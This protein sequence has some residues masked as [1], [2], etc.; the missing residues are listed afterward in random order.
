MRA[1][2]FSGSYHVFGNREEQMRQI[3]KATPPPM[4]KAIAN[5]LHKHFSAVLEAVCVASDR[6]STGGTSKKRKADG[7]IQNNSGK[8]V[9]SDS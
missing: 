1:H 9:R 3:N 5:S 6:E 7:D 2:G 8:K 4:A